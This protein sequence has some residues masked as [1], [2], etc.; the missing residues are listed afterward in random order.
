MHA[1]KTCTESEGLCIAQMKKWRFFSSCWIPDITSNIIFYSKELNLF[2]R[3]HPRHIL[4]D[5]Y[6]V[7]DSV[8][9]TE[10]T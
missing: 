5:V 8:L 7:S 4:L 1:G 6:S 2:V 9:D 3:S 10:N